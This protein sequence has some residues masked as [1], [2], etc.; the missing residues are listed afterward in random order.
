MK[1]AIAFLIDS[2]LLLG[3]LVLCVWE[4][5]RDRQKAKTRRWLGVRNHEGEDEA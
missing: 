4:W 3:F 5:R 2:G 1:W